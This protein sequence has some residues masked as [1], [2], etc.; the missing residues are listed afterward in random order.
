MKTLSVVKLQTK[1]TKITKGI[2]NEIKRHKY[3][4]ITSHARADGD[5]IGS[6]LA[7]NFMLKKLGKTSH[8]VCDYGAIPEYKFLPGASAV[9]EGPSDLRDH[10]DAMFVVDC[11][12]IDRLE[13]LRAKIPS[14][15]FIINIDHHISN[16][17][18]ADI[19]WVDASF[20]AT[21]E[22]VYYLIKN[23]KV[24]IDKY[25]AMNLY[26]SI[27]TDTGGFA[28]S[29]TKVATHQITA[30]LLSIGVNPAYINKMLY[31]QKTMEQ[32]KLLSRIIESI[33]MTSDGKIAWTSLTNQ[34]ANDCGFY[35]YE[36]QEY[37]NA[38]KSLKTVKVAILLRELD[39]QP[40]KIKVSFRAD[41]P[42]DGSKLAL[43]WGGGGHM[44]A[45]GAMINGNL[46]KV[47]EEV[48]RKTIEFVKRTNNSLSHNLKVKPQKFKSKVKTT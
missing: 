4:L 1:T 35:P 13:R 28:F 26:V 36:T 24:K 22:M 12:S 39:D 23:S 47:E 16:T 19:N 42:V 43:I 10:Y 5:A 32:L 40:G 38:I 27:Y 33:S 20:A 3:F 46:K 8:V 25:M 31:R 9:G 30:D 2:L 41:D 15:P 29:N 34:M 37:I 11:A 18:F 14:K 17:R 7:I 6:A 44:R 21:G 48:I 45:S